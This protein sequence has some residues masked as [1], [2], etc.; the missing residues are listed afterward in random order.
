MDVFEEITL[1]VRLQRDVAFSQNNQTIPHPLRRGHWHPVYE[2]LCIRRGWGEIRINNRVL[3]FYPG[4]V[5][6]IRPGDVHSNAY[7]S[8][9]GCDV[10]ILQFTSVF[11]DQTASGA[12]TLSSGIIHPDDP[13]FRQVFDALPRC[14]DEHFPGYEHLLAGVVHLIIG[15]LLRIENRQVMRSPSSSI[16]QICA[17][18][19]SADDLQLSRV[20]C[21]FNY[22][23]EHLSR[24]FHA[25]T[26]ISYRQ[27]C[28]R[29]RMERAA[30]LLAGNDCSASDIAEKLGYSSASSF[31]RAFRQVY[32]ISPSAYRRGKRTARVIQDD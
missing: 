26:G 14:A 32:G 7:L 25:E 24:K 30:S 15:L 22:S 10:D 20:A 2:V 6:V 17:Y 29:L 11:F 31:I 27:W 28:S 12:R 19:E 16:Q 8:A 4:D 1:P 21:H 3:P 13:S 18:L 23:P 9:D 5:V